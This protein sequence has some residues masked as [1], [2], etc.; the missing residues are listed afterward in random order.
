MHHHVQ[1]VIN[2]FICVLVCVSEFMCTPCM[3]VLTET[4]EDACELLCGCREPNL[5]PVQ[6]LSNV[7]S[8]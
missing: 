7:L 3:H 4:G 2:V 5:G 8:P 6:E 1:P